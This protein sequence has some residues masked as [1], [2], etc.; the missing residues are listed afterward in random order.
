MSITDILN[1][2]ADMGVFAYVIP[3]LLIFAVVFAILQKTK[4]LGDNNPSVQAIV[5]LAVGLLSLQFDFVSTF[6]AEIFPKFGIGLAVFLVLIILLGFFYSGA[7]GKAEGAIKWIGWFTGIAVVVWAL[8]SWNFWADN[9]SI[10]WWIEEY[11][12]PI[13]VLAAVIAIIVVVAKSGSDSSG[14]P[15]KV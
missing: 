9:W 2:W 7:D 13:I 4:L 15:P 11:F 8:S 1:T 6:Y 10:G 12:W 5:A 3:F 14:K